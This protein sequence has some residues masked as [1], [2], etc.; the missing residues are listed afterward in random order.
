MK[1]LVHANDQRQLLE[2]NCSLS[3]TDRKTLIFQMTCGL[4]IL[5]AVTSMVTNIVFALSLI[6]LKL[7]H[8]NM[9]SLLAQ[10]SGAF[11]IISAHLAVRAVS[12]LY[13]LDDGKQ[14]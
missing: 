2:Q 12:R 10:K 4:T 8:K 1:A 11:V 9:K 14:K 6:G 7:L 5:L 13:Q 3:M